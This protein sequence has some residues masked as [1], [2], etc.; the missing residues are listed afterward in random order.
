MPKDTILLTGATGALGQM[1]LPR[2][3]TAGFNIV[4]LVRAQDARTA[5]QRIIEIVGRNPRVKAIRG[6]I[7][8]PQCGIS[9]LDQSQ[10]FGRVRRILHSAAC[11][12]FEDRELTALTNVGGVHHLLELADRLDVWNVLHVSTAYV[13]G[14]ADSFAETDLYKGQR[15]RNCYEESKYIGET[16]VKSWAL[17]RDDRRV[18]IFRPSILFACTDGT[19]PTFDG[20]YTFT[21]A[22]ARIADSLRRKAGGDQIALQVDSDGTLHLPLVMQMADITVN[23]V[24]ID[25]VA[26]AMVHLISQ[27]PRN[28]TYHLVHD[29]PP[30]ISNLTSWSL[31]Y[32]KITGVHIV[33]TRAEKQ[34]AIAMQ[35]PV[36]RLL[37]KKLDSVHEAYVP[38]CTS[39]PA[40]STVATR[41]ALGNRYSGPP[42]INQEY[43]QRTIAFAIRHHWGRS[44]RRSELVYS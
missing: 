20:Y 7:T 35:S 6:D 23:Y 41:A 17:K 44:I 32:L 33:S 25:W 40:F 31:D 16:L 22:L 37:Q 13:A 9:D 27:H 3:V 43:V 28:S 15:W 30:L 12:N 34:A 14:D 2:L 38:Y 21:G 26:D 8:E 29:R 11:V 24:G 1:L 10:L 4:C 5:N 39:D 19:T 42:I 36:V 18:S